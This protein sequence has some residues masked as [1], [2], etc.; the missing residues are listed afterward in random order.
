M[1]FSELL[2]IV[3]FKEQVQLGT[4]FLFFTENTENSSS[5]HTGSF[6]FQFLHCWLICCFLWLEVC[7]WKHLIWWNSYYNWIIHSQCFANSSC[8]QLFSC[9]CQCH[10]VCIFGNQSSH[11]P[12]LMLF[13]KAPQNVINCV[14]TFSKASDSLLSFVGTKILNPFLRTWF[15]CSV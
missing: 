1:R 5:L 4:G 2:K 7:H 9:F 12:N 15:K 13:I 11:F 8:K 14:D 10:N 6:T 3:R